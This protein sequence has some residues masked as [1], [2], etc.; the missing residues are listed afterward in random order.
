MLFIFIKIVYT[1][2]RKKESYILYG[3]KIFVS[4]NIGI[5]SFLLLHIF[6]SREFLK[7]KF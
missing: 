7:S 6:E 2:N 3:Y 1:P 4:H 5:V